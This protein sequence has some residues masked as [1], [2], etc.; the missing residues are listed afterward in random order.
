M[1]QRISTEIKLRVRYFAFSLYEFYKKSLEHKLS[2][3]DFQTIELVY[4]LPADAVCVDIGMNEGQ[5]LHAMVNHCKEG[6]I[7]GF[8]P[9]PILFKFLFNKYASKRVSLHQIALSD[10]EEYCSFYYY[11]SRSAVSGLSKR[12]ALFG[13]D[14]AQ[15]IKLQTMCLD[16]LLNLQRLDLIKID[17]E[18][19]ELRVLKGSKEHIQRCRPIIVF[20]CGK[21]GIDF[22]NDK[23]EEVYDFFDELGYSLSLPKYYLE[24]HSPLDRHTFLLFFNHGYEYQFVAYH[25]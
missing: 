6:K 3:C 8:E 12:E 20:E 16:Q 15:S 11:P 7:Y 24:G 1:N 13:K 19:A 10:T 22:F 2:V 14:R 17:V 4:R 5:I 18:G 9:I 21:G 23:P 25:K